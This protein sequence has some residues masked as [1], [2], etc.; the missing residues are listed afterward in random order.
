MPPRKN[1]PAVKRHDNIDS[2][3]RYVSSWRLLATDRVEAVIIEAIDPH[4]DRFTT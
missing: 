3:P 1:S 2:G 4:T